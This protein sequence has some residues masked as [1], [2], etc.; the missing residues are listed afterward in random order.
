MENRVL[1]KTIEVCKFYFIHDDSSTG[2]PGYIVWKD[3]VANRYL[4][5]AIKKVKYQKIK[6]ALDIL[7]D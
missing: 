4:V 6:E 5:V 2:H 7:L 1:S 3:D